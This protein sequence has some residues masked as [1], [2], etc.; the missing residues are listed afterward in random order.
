MRVA[1]LEIYGIPRLLIKSWQENVG[2]E[3]LPMQAIAVKERGLLEKGNLII[4]APTSSGKTFCAEIAMARALLN[5][6]KAVYLVPLKALAEERYREF[7]RKYEPL[8]LKTII[9]TSDR[10][11]FDRS[12]SRGDFNLAI[13]IFEKMNQILSTSL[14]L[15]S[16]IDLVVID[17]LQMIADQSRGA[18]LEMALLKIMHSK[19]KCRL[20]GLSAVLSGAKKLAGW[21]D[22]G[23]F[24][25][26]HRPVDLYQG[27]LWRGEYAYR[28]QNSG[29]CGSERLLDDDSLLP[30][31]QLLETVNELIKRGEKVLVFLKSKAACR[32]YAGLLSERTELPAAEATIENLRL[33]SQTALSPAIN[34]LLQRG[35][36][37]H[38][39]D[40]SFEQRKAIEEGYRNDEI[41]ILFATTTLSM[42]LNLP[43]TTVLLEPFKFTAGHYGEHALPQHLSWPEYENMCGR[44]GRLRYVRNPGR[45]M[46]LVNS[47]F[48]KEVIWSKFIEGRPSGLEGQLHTREILDVLLDLVCSGCC[49]SMEDLTCIL[50]RSFSGDGYFA[51][52][53]EA[54]LEVCRNHKWI[55]SENGIL[56]GTA[57]GCTISGFGITAKSAEKAILL[58]RSEPPV[59]KLLWLFEFVNSTEVNRNSSSTQGRIGPDIIS[60]LKGNS[61]LKDYQQ[62]RL[63]RVISNPELMNHAAMIRIAQALAL[64]DWC[65]GTAVCEIESSYQI[66]AGSLLNLAETCAWLSES[67]AA[68]ARVLN[69]SRNIGLFF[70]RFAFTLR[71]GLCIELRTIWKLGRE[72][73]GRDDYY[74][75]FAHGIRNSNDLVSANRDTLEKNLGASKAEKIRNKIEVAKNKN[76]EDKMNGELACKLVLEGR[77]NRDRLTVRFF[78]RE[79]PLTLKSFKYLAKLACAKYLDAKNNG[80]LHKD[81]LEPGFNQARYIY[82]LKKELGLSKNQGLLE[83]N[84]SGYYRLNLTPDEIELNLENLKRIQDYELKSIAERYENLQVSS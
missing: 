29:E 12:F 27:I 11:E 14:D 59:E 45:A 18:V 72:I 16:Y 48:E 50:A 10:K 56:S 40:L 37:F 38:H 13:V 51:G 3:L 77:S 68:I 22:A 28:K 17:E 33:C 80:W 9:S 2:S 42:G 30:E 34:E 82:N 62:F 4:S 47:E 69:L 75:L 44:A 5:G 26:G 79:L 54:A 63:S 61:E 83:N 64:I 70:K 84:R 7:S 57:L 8:G 52:K 35:I 73:L 55:E 71:Y 58:L 65:D 25:Y 81:Q 76:K 46:I 67:T 15:L 20:L 43:A 53:V 19:Y 31:E 78:G 32:Y 66:S 39:A 1:D 49:R 74:R 41:K 60:E 6:Q 23:L 36:A 21:L 24:I